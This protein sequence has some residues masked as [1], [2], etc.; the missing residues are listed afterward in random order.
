MAGELLEI[1]VGSIMLGW[2]VLKPS[3][4]LGK[5]GAWHRFSYIAQKENKVLAF[6]VYPGVGDIEVIRTYCKAIDTE[7]T[8][9]V[10][11]PAGC[12][13]ERGRELAREFEVRILNS[14]NV[15]QFFRSLEIH[16]S[17]MTP[18]MA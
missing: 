13:T 18:V 1:E 2:S 8:V 17:A 11:C 3:K 12:V 5:S 9:A 10:V 4:L 14:E 6:D 16:A 15:V 7:A